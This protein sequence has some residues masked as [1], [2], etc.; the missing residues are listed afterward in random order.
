KHA[1]TASSI[2]CH[3]F[4]ALQRQWR[5]QAF[6]SF[7]ARAPRSH[8]PTFRD[9]GCCTCRANTGREY[10]DNNTS[11]SMK[12]MQMH[13]RVRP[14]ASLDHFHAALLALCSVNSKLKHAQHNATSMSMTRTTHFTHGRAATSDVQC[15]A[16]LQSPRSTITQLYLR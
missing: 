6:R 14:V 12:F 3:S 5:W 9:I 10:N 7:A 15:V 1:G 8:P 4:R 2:V 11:Y 16:V 13:S